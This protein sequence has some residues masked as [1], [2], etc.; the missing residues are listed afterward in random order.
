MHTKKLALRCYCFFYRSE[1][2]VYLN[3][4]HLPS[5]KMKE[6]IVFNESEKLSRQMSN[7]KKLERERERKENF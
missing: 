6:N 5:F 4:S 2:W 7:I 1:R 3:G